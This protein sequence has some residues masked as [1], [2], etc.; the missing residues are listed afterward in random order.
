MCICDNCL[1]Q[2]SCKS[3]KQNDENLEWCAFKYSLPE[4]LKE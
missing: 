1:H 3:D 4:A 2:D